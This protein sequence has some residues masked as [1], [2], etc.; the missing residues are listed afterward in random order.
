MDNNVNDSIDM[1]EVYYAIKDKLWL[2]IVGGIIAAL[3]TGLVTYFLVNPVYS[4]SAKLYVLG[5]VETIETFSDL[6]IGSMLTNDFM[7]IIKSHEVVIQVL[8]NMDLDMSADELLKS[9][10]L[11][12]DADTRILEI[13]IKNH[14]PYLAKDIADEFAKV[15]TL[16]I[17][18]IMSITQPSMMDDPYVSL[19]PV[20]P[21]LYKNVAIA[22]VV[23]AV[24]VV[25]IIILLF[26]MDDTVKSADDIEKYLKLANLSSIPYNTNLLKPEKRRKNRVRKQ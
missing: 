7:E 26:I 2:V 19:T 1:R 15:S 6:Q 10:T 23:G 16:Q 8:D 21:N 17:S 14:N 4:S 24:G 12:S 20:S 25:C 13:K 9:M 22:G 5:N 18:K 3:I 11:V